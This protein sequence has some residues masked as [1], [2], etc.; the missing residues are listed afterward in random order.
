[1]YCN[2]IMSRK[3]RTMLSKLRRQSRVRSYRE[4]TEITPLLATQKNGKSIS[5]G[6]NGVNGVNGFTEN[7]KNGTTIHIQNVL[8][9]IEENYAGKCMLFVFFFHKVNIYYDLQTR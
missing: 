9:P 3:T 1:M 2:D 7:G 5:N 8:Y 6:L 4:R